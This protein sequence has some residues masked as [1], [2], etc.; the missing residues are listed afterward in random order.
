VRPE[1]LGKL[2]KL[3]HIFG[4][5]TSDLPACSSELT[6]RYPNRRI[7]DVKGDKIKREMKQGN[8]IKR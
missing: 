7:S 1:G 8:K 4:S 3:I 5:R 6:P 2:K